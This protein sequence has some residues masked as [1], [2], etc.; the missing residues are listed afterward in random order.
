MFCVDQNGEVKSAISGSVVQEMPSQDDES[1]AN[2]G[3]T[4]S[5][6]ERV[7]ILRDE[8]AQV[9][10][11]TELFKWSFH[12]RPRG[13]VNFSRS[14]LF[15]PFSFLSFSFIFILLFLLSLFFSFFLLFFFSI[16][17]SFSVLVL[18]FFVRMQ[19]LMYES[20]KEYIS[21]A[22]KCLRKL[23]LQHEQHQHER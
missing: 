8:L 21:T 17:L 14:L 10:Q 11:T 22:E 9:L 19:T 20:C 18:S 23:Y 15:P 2:D 1:V 5:H 16:F 13:S 4:G 12:I 6:A 7:D 3:E